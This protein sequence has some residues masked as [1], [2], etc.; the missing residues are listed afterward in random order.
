MFFILKNQ[1]FFSCLNQHQIRKKH[2]TFKIELNLF[3]NGAL[4]QF[5]LYDTSERLV[6][7]LDRWRYFEL[8]YVDWYLLLAEGAM[9]VIF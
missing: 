5:V 3:V 7:E 6:G 8:V 2:I 9:R 1:L 4:Q